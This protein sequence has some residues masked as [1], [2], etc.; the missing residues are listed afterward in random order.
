[1]SFSAPVDVIVPF[2][3][4]GVAESDETKLFELLHIPELFVV[5]DVIDVPMLLTLRATRLLALAV[6]RL[7][8]SSRSNDF[9][10]DT[11]IIEA[12][13]E[14]GVTLSVELLTPDEFGTEDVAFAV[15]CDKDSASI[16]V[17]VNDRWLLLLLLLRVLSDE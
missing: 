15:D 3:V 10:G 6:I 4:V 12:R 2:E 16:G 14:V 8:R 9:S 17:D 13:L 7:L 11:L 5:D 1:V